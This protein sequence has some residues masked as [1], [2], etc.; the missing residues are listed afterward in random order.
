MDLERFKLYIGKFVAVAV[1]H[2]SNFEKN[3]YHYGTLK[4][5][6]DCLEILTKNGTVFVDKTQ[7]LSVEI[8][9]NDRNVGRR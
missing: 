3:F 5:V 7:V 1:P 9:V 8:G 2:K 4:S 6:D